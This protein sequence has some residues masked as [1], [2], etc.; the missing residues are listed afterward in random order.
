MD[1]SSNR[2][3][4]K[5][6]CDYFLVHIIYNHLC[7]YIFKQCSSV[8]EAHG[9]IWCNT[10]KDILRFIAIARLIGKKRDEKTIIWKKPTFNRSFAQYDTAF[11]YFIPTILHLRRKEQNLQA[12]R[13]ITTLLL[14]EVII[15]FLLKWKETHCIFV[16]MPFVLCFISE[17]RTKP[18]C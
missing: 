4:R 6:S 18:F 12:N 11:F 1:I 13:W 2:R 8:E 14:E 17:I 16:S 9:C 5:K 7:F 10:R 15:L 3:T